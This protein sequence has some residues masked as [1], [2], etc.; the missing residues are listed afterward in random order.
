MAVTSTIDV[1][2]PVLNSALDSSVMRANFTAAKAD[3]DSVASTF[4]TTSDVQFR[5]VTVRKLK[6]GTQTAPTTSFTS[7]L[8]TVGNSAAIT[9]TGTDTMMS[10]AI[11]VGSDSTGT[12]NFGTITFNTAYSAT[13]LIM[14]T[15]SSAS[16]ST[17]ALQSASATAI[18]FVASTTGIAINTPTT[19]LTASASYTYR[20]LVIG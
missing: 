20:I 12:G 19:A 15:P 2:K 9:C 14:V 4:S 11:Q 18:S 10:V 3:I 13:P 16:A 17:W 1:T 5:D 8:G 7:V 6:R